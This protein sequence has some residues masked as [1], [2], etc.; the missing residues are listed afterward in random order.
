MSH[1]DL[2]ELF[3][4]LGDSTR[5]RIVLLLAKGP[6]NVSSLCDSL[7]L[8]QP[9]ISHHLALL[10]R[11]GMILNRREGKQVFY[12]LN[13]YADG[14]DHNLQITTS[15]FRIQVQSNG[16]DMTPATAAVR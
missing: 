15:Q 4:L 1:G 13:G 11:M 16:S 6:R 2:A 14:T 7:L 8:P 10:R 5:L 12:S 9:T 3:G